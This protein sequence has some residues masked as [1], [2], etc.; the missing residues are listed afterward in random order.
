VRR[1]LP[2]AAFE[3]GPDV[4]DSNGRQVPLR[5]DDERRVLCLA[6][7]VGNGQ[8]LVDETLRGVDEDER[9]VRPGRSLTR[10]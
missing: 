6:R 8:I 9:D 3:L 10:P 5:E 4:V 2:Q 7:N 1:A